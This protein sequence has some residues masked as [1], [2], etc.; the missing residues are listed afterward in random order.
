MGALLGKDHPLYFR[1]ALAE[2][3]VENLLTM[4]QKD[5]KI[6]QSDL[7]IAQSDLK[8]AQSDLK[9]A[10]ND[11]A[12]SQKLSKELQDY[13]S[14]VVA[15][16]LVEKVEEHIFGNQSPLSRREKWR[17]ILRQGG[18]EDLRKGLKRCKIPRFPSFVVDFVRNSSGLI[19]NT[20]LVRVYKP[21]SFF[22]VKNSCFFSTL[23]EFCENEGIELKNEDYYIASFKAVK[24]D[25]EE[26]W[27]EEGKS[28]HLDDVS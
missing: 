23:Y 6:A 11:L 1:A 9:I 13:Q 12:L 26:M 5:V 7:K 18:H 21:P 10:Q 27:E 28:L 4:A 16:G 25:I 15:R 8:I 2:A 20:N 14:M 19:H 3:K 24:K 22:G 17:R